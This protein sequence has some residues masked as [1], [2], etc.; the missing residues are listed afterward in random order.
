[1]RRAW[2]EG[3]PSH[4]GDVSVTQ[5]VHSDAVAVL[6]SVFSQGCQ[7]LQSRSRGVELGHKGR[8]HRWP[9]WGKT[10]S[11]GGY[12]LPT[13][14][15]STC[16]VSVACTVHGDAAA[17]VIEVVLRIYKNI[18]GVNQSR[19]CGV[20]L[21]HEGIAVADVGRLEGTRRDG[22][23]GACTPGEVNVAPTV[24]GYP[25]APG[26]EKCGVNQGG[27][28]GIKFSHEGVTTVAVTIKIAVRLERTGMVGK[29]IETV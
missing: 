27:S 8:L 6:R 2:S 15:C 17:V 7:V 1:M 14:L 23:V 29:S 9:C 5:A 10:G 3:F 25:A 19:S 11:S 26:G 22:Q 24:Q 4:S 13:P 28:R 12:S 16:D 20:E 21:G 18:C